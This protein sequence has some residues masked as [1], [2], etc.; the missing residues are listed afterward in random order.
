M[1]QAT[2]RGQISGKE[3]CWLYGMNI[4]KWGT[5]ERYDIR[6]I[7]STVLVFLQDWLLA[8]PLGRVN[9]C[10]SS[11]PNKNSWPLSVLL[12]FLIYTWSTLEII[13]VEQQ[14]GH[15]S[16]P[17]KG[18][19]STTLRACLFKR[20]L[21]EEQIAF[22]RA[23]VTVQLNRIWFWCPGLPSPFTVPAFHISLLQSSSHG[24]FF[25]V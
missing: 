3:E 1:H 21:S 5:V 4:P 11:L 2:Y 22:Q 13:L 12:F 8:F 7:A 14:L 25:P 24:A 18:K 17:S 15:G 19:H 20:W 16:M 23:L 6:A 9:A 10:V